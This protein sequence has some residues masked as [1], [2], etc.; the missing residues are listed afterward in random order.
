MTTEEKAKKWDELDVEVSKFYLNANGEYDEENPVRKGDLGT[1]GEI[2]A[3]KL[4]WL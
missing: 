2:A 4:G 3:S 1:I